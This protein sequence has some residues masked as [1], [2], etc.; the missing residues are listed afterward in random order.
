MPKRTSNAHVD[1]SSRASSQA[2]GTKSTSF[3]G[4]L[5][6]FVSRNEVDLVLLACEDAGRAIGLN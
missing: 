3:Q 6:H 2:N 1:V 4:Y 5:V